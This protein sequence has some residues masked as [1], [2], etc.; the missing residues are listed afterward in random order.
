M[1]LGPLSQSHVITDALVQFQSLELHNSNEA[2]YRK[3]LYTGR[4]V[5]VIEFSCS[6]VNVAA[7]LQIFLSPS[8]ASGC[9]AGFA[10]APPCWPFGPD[11][12]LGPLR[13]RDPGRNRLGRPH[14]CAASNSRGALAGG[15]QPAR[16]P[17][18]TAHSKLRELLNCDA[19]V[20]NEYSMEH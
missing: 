5:G 18:S 19:A 6:I 11:P 2:F 7:P 13:F 14:G 1:Q 10:P 15:L 9:F 20:L 4:R 17:V 12:G 3:I 16:T 8:A